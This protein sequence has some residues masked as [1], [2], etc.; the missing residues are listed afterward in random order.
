MAV[1]NLLCLLPDGHL[2]VAVWAPHP[3]GGWY[4]IEAWC[5]GPGGRTGQWMPSA[6]W[7]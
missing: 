7:P 5:Y 4:V 3:E 2:P 6:R 1:R